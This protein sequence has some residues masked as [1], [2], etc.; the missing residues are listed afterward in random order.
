MNVTSNP[1]RS[2]M[3]DRAEVILWDEYG[4]VDWWKARRSLR[5]SENLTR[6]GINYLNQVF[7]ETEELLGGYKYVGVHLRRQDFVYGRRK[8][9]LPSVQ[10]AA[11]QAFQIAK[12]LKLDGIFLAT[13]GT[14]DG[15]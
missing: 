8:L 15:K 7:N 12:R 11:K 9:T 10:G 14:A 13:D 2:I 4:G 5:F 3:F 6:I 1:F